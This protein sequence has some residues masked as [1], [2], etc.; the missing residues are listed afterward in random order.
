MQLDQ[1][2]DRVHAPERVVADVGGHEPP[3]GGGPRRV[4][5]LRRGD[6]R[7]LDGRQNLGREAGSLEGRGDLVAADV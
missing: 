7:H 3:L 1:R 2:P 6:A 5:V 4:G